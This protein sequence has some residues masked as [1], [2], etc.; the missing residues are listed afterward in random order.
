MLGHC[1]ILPNSSRDLIRGVG[2]GSFIG[3]TQGRRKGEN[4]RVADLERKWVVTLMPLPR[5]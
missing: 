4:R 5:A 1:V 3:Q 2:G